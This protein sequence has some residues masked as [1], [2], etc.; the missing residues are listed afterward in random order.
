[1]SSPEDALDALIQLNRERQ[2]QRAAEPVLVAKYLTVGGATVDITQVNDLDEP[3]HHAS[4]TGCG[5]YHNEVWGLGYYA[6]NRHSAAQGALHDT[7]TWTQDHAS[8]CRAMPMPEA[9]R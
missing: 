2:A 5:T 6:G 4:C 9:T 8:A 7:R 3:L 1:M